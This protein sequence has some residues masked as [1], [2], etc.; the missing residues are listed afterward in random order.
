MA[1][2]NVEACDTNLDGDFN[3]VSEVYEN[4]YGIDVS[5]TFTTD[6]A[7]QQYFR[8]RNSSGSAITFNEIKVHFLK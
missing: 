5:Y 7:F 8:L 2:F 4:T 3:V 1:V 6:S